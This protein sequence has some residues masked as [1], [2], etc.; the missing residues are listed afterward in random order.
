MK[1]EGD[2]LLQ[3]ERSISKGEIKKNILDWFNYRPNSFSF[4]LF[5]FTL[6]GVN[7]KNF[8]RII[9]ETS[10]KSIGSRAK[11]I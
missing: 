1:K 11:C 10:M 7:L 8:H 5:S 2:C 6:S 4:A 3:L 9:V